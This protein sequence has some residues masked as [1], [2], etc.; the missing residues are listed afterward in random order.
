MRI[1]MIGTGYVGRIL[2]RN[3]PCFPAGLDSKLLSSREDFVWV[4]SAEFFGIASIAGGPPS[5]RCFCSA[6]N[7]SAASSVPAPRGVEPPYVAHR[8]PGISTNC[9]RH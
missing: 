7:P 6:L 9:E 8:G 1:T 4:R 3:D 2:R 5:Q